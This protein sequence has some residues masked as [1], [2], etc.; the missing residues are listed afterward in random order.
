MSVLVRG[1]TLKI[2]D[3]AVG[4][5]LVTNIVIIIDVCRFI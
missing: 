2:W 3:L 5:S 4:L 1:I